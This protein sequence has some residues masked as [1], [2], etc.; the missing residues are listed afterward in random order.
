MT[1]MKWRIYGQEYKHLTKSA[2]FGYCSNLQLVLCK[3]LSLSAASI[4][5]TEGLFIYIYFLLF[6]E[7][8]RNWIS[9]AGEIISPTI[10]FFLRKMIV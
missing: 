6:E 3:R 9:R 7:N 5:V 2:R 4:F 1:I 10:S 8:H